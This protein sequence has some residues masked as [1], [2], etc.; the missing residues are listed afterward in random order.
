MARYM[1]YEPPFFTP[2]TSHLICRR[3]RRGSADQSAFFHRYHIIDAAFDAARYAICLLFFID[4]YA[5]FA[6]ELRDVSPAHA[7]PPRRYA[8]MPL[9][10]VALLLL[11]RHAM[12][13]ALR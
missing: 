13:S 3:R 1:L 9:L 11:R 8:A 2:F 7:M 10:A 12:L 4:A 5:I 6:D